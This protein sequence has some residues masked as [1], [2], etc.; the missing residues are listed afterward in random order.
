MPSPVDTSR[1][2]KTTDHELESLIASYNRKWERETL[3]AT[4]SIRIAQRPSV[5]ALLAPWL[6]MDR[7]EVK[8][9]MVQTATGIIVS[10][11]G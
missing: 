1:V 8:Q 3:V 10:Q 9:L 11:Q 4:T 6:N 5:L 2:T 7:P